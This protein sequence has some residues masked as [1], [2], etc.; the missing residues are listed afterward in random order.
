MSRTTR[1]S[2][3]AVS[4]SCS[5]FAYSQGFNLRISED[6]QTFLP[7]LLSTLTFFEDV[8]VTASAADLDLVFDLDIP[9]SDLK[10]AT[11]LIAHFESVLFFVTP[12]AIELGC[13]FNQSKNSGVSFNSAKSGCAFYSSL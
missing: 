7:S 10:R 6:F 12:S 8:L 9:A 3:S 5:T 13:L 11:T 2:R 4:I 1:P